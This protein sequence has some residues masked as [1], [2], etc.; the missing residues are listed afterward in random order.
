MDILISHG[1]LEFWLIHICAFVMGSKHLQSGGR[2]SSLLWKSCF[3]LSRCLK[4]PV[5]YLVL[6]QLHGA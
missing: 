3:L 2:Y 4:L 1:D 6:G 5:I